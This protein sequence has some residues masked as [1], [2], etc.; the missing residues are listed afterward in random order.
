M[1]KVIKEWA[2]AIVTAGMVSAVALQFVA[3]TVVSGISMEPAFHERDYL[4]VS[5]QAY[6]SHRKPQRGDVVIFHSHLKDEN[7]QNKDLI[8]RV[9]AVPG[10]TVAVTDGKV[11]ING[12][13]FQDRYAKDGVT[14]GNVDPVKIPEGYLFCLGDNR[15]HSTDSR[16][17]EVGLVSDR[18]IAGKAVF[19]VFPLDKIGRI[20]E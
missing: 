7:N 2:A 10:E 4:I 3:P 19:R 1:K 14:N 18:D 13:E 6:N 8:K 20:K 5:K 11:Y 17:M 9:I 12:E 16:V 15:L